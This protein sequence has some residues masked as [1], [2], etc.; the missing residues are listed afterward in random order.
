M[1]KRLFQ[2]I[3]FLFILLFSVQAYADWK[4]NPFTGK[5]DYYE[6]GGAG[7]ITTVGTCT[8]GNCGIEGGMDIFPFIYEGT[9]DEFETIFAVTDPT[10]PD[11]TITFPDKTG[12]VA[13]N[14]DKLSAFAATTSAELA[15]VI[16]D[17]TGSGSLV[18]GTNPT[19]TGATMA[20]DLNFA[21]YKAVAMACDN[22]TSF[23]ATPNTGQWFYRSDIKTLFIYEA[24]WKSI[25]SFGAVTLYVDGVNGTDAVGKGYGS[26]TS[27]TKTIQYAIDLIPQIN[28][29]N[30]VVNITAATY[31][32]SFS[33]AHKSVSG[34]Y[35]ITIIGTRTNLDTL[36]AAASVQGTGATQGTVVRNSG[37]WTT[38][39][40]QNKLVRFTS[41]AN[42]GVSR[43]IDSNTTTTLTIVGTWPSAVGVGDT[44][45]VE[46]WGTIIN[47][48]QSIEDIR[49]AVFAD[50]NLNNS[51][52]L[53]L[54]IE[55]FSGVTL[56]NVL[57]TS[58]YAGDVFQVRFFSSLLVNACM[59]NN[60]TGRGMYSDAGFTDFKYT[61]IK[62]SSAQSGISFDG[63]NGAFEYGSVV[64]GG[65]N[66]VEIQANGMCNFYS[67]ASGG[68]PRIRN[69]TNGIRAY[70][71]GA[72]INTGTNVYSGNVTDENATA[73]SFG[74]ID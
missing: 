64:E 27:A 49:G 62:V 39:Q 17:E 14:T 18:F 40:R 69:C 56:T 38:D 41:G 8:T 55:N 70:V 44:F 60:T 73:A 52:N 1:N 36:T 24:A 71:G 51:A 57:L 42:S 28:G 43:I 74:Y 22:G 63:A 20:A 58:G 61:K 5:L 25:I 59:I 72:G 37:V 23:P 32:E 67:P 4:F 53:D 10:T 11:K 6:A 54:I 50:L 3:V 26:G 45:V 7:D 16:S 30:V 15:G 35:T 68:Y 31:T 29:G 65:N 9:A 48:I 19:L 46:D 12:T 21:K 2:A 34:D 66:G 33:L 13:L 47:G